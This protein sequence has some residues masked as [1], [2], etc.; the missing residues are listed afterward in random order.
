MA[1]VSAPPKDRVV[2][3]RE[4]G[5]GAPWFHIA[6][7]ANDN[8][9]SGPLTDS[10]GA[11][12]PVIITWASNDSWNSDGGN[13]T[14]DEK[15][16]KGLVKIQGLGNTLV[17]TFN[18]VPNGLYDLY[19]YTLTNGATS[20]LDT[21]A[22]AALGASRRDIRPRHT[23]SRDRRTGMLLA[24]GSGS[25]TIAET[26]Q[27]Q[28]TQPAHLILWT[29]PLSVAPRK[30]FTTRADAPSPVSVTSQLQTVNDSSRQA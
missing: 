7:G 22:R 12:T 24:G 23:R 21:P 26:R 3:R 14:P 29:V 18:N 11:A 30:I 8:A 9:T 5:A 19:A 25:L 6:N 28:R 17:L 20:T 15:L 13:T 1:S 27:S 10:T 16:T 2:P 4:R